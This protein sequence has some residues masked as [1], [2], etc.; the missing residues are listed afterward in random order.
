MTPTGTVT[1]PQPVQRGLVGIEPPPEVLEVRCAMVGQMRRQAEL[2]L[3]PDGQHAQL[4]IDMAQPAHG[5]HSRPPLVAV[6][7]A[8]AAEV[9][10]LEATARQLAPGTLALVMC[11]GFDYDYQRHEVRALKC[12][13]IKPIPASEAPGFIPDA[14]L[15][16]PEHTS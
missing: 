1:R 5:G 15:D 10:T 7:H 4:V 8:G 3:S 13:R 14:Q 12:D 6:Y 9:P 16:N 11:R 2:R